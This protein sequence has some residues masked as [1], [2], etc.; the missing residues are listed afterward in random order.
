M[1][2]RDSEYKGTATAGSV[3]TLARGAMGED[4]DGYR[5]EFVQ[6]VERWRGMARGVADR[7]VRRDR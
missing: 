6:L 3:L 1:L 7:P 5:A 4:D 2:L